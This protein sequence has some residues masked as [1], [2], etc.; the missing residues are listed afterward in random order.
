MCATTT[1]FWKVGTKGDAGS[2][3]VLR[4]NNKDLLIGIVSAKSSIFPIGPT[5]FTRVSSFKKWIDEALMK[6][7]STINSSTNTLP[8]TAFTLGAPKDEPTTTEP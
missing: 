3:L 4:K 7:A 2:P 1:G 8:T 6:S 5:V